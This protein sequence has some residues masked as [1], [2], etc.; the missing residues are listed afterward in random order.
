MYFTSKQ[1]VPI[2]NQDMRIMFALDSSCYTLLAVLLLTIWL[3]ASCNTTSVSYSWAV[4][5]I[6][7]KRTQHSFS[8]ASADTLKSASKCSVKLI[9][10]LRIAYFLYHSMQGSHG[11]KVFAQVSVVKEICLLSSPVALQKIFKI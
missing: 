10:L 2:W 11:K 4:S 9:C 7:T 6:F 5:R 8:M 3:L 1:I